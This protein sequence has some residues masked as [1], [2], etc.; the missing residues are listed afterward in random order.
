MKGNC[1][2][3]KRAVVEYIVHDKGCASTIKFCNSRKPS[4]PN[5]YGSDKMWIIGG[6]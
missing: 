4:Q 6:K 2:C 5:F 3:G 1:N